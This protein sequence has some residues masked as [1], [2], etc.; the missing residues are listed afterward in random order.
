MTV[1]HSPLSLFVSSS[2]LLLCSAEGDNR[3]LFTKVSKEVLALISKG[4]HTFVKVTPSSTPLDLN[5]ATLSDMLYLFSTRE[6]LQFL[7]LGSNLQTKMA[8][9][10]TLFKVWMLESSDEIQGAAMSFGS[11]IVLQQS[12]AIVDKLAKS[13]ANDVDRN[14]VKVLT[15]LIL[16][17][18]FR[19]I[20]ID[21]PWFLTNKILSI[22]QGQQVTVRVRE[23]CAA[24]APYALSLVK[25]FGIPDH[26]CLAPIAQDWVEYNRYDNRGEVKDNLSF[27]TKK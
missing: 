19:R 2:S 5:R 21:L 25:A 14:T 6:K 22:E 13:A 16:L 27:V 24:I 15:T 9:G 23:L 11:R 7:T 17:Y 12:I 8:A 3:V 10:S 20:E 26:L 4:K 1:I 18:A